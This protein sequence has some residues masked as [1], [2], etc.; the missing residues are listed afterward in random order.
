M[1]I[2]GDKR[3]ILD[4]FC[5]RN[6]TI[7]FFDLSKEPICREYSA[8]GNKKAQPKGYMIDESC[9]GC[10]TCIIHC[11]QNCIDEGQPFKINQM[12][13]LHCGACVENC[14]VGAIKQ[15]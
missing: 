11:P 5:I 9:I 7:E 2:R 8:I 13:C 6:A 12:H 4:V 15:I 3:Q 1:F 14:P 10:A